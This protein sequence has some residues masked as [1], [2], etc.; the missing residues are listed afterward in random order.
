[1]LAKIGM[2]LIDKSLICVTAISACQ[3]LLQDD[4]LSMET[5]IFDWH[6]SRVF[7]RNEQNQRFATMPKYRDISIIVPSIDCQIAL[8][9]RISFE[10]ILQLKFP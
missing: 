1:M 6:E 10:K 3:P 8:M 4:N 9:S 5:P 7:M 2:R